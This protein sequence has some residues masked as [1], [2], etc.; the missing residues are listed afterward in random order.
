MA[1][2]NG[3]WTHVKKSDPERIVFLDLFNGVLIMLSIKAYIK[4]GNLNLEETV[5]GQ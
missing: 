5:K 4:S 2:G 1:V 3:S